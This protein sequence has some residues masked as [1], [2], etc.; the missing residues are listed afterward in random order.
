MSLKKL[1]ET[2]GVTSQQKD[3]E[4]TE[5]LLNEHIDEFRELINYW[6]MYPD[7]L[8]DYYC[9][10]NPKNTFHLFF[11]QRLFLRII[12]RHR[13]V[14]AVFVRAWSKSFM[15]VMALMLKAI[16]YPGA[17]LFSVAGGKEQSAQILSS[18]VQEICQL[19]PAMSKEII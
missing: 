16:L 15:S 4:V 17:K 7:R 2:A 9:S 11:Y 12:M 19:I 6:R 8:I 1:L 3:I 13:Y 5:E 10:L 18:K 14:Y